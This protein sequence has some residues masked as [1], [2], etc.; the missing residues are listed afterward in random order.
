MPQKP[1]NLKACGRLLAQTVFSVHCPHPRLFHN[2]PPRS[3]LFCCLSALGSLS[4]GDHAE[5]GGKGNAIIQRIAPSDRHRNQEM[6][7][8]GE[9]CGALEISVESGEQEVE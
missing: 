1:A 5:Y 8:R 2:K 3:W 7:R 4:K 9:H 6:S